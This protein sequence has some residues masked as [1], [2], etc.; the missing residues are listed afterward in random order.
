[1]DR[2]VTY[3]DDPI[4]FKLLEF[5]EFQ[6]NYSRNNKSGNVAL[7]TP[8]VLSPPYISLQHKF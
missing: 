6:Q 2:K 5:T 3:N 7:F 8:Q 4:E 1:M